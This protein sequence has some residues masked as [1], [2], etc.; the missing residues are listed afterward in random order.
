MYE[1]DTAPPKPLVV[2]ST[3]G[4]S[5]PGERWQLSPAALG[6]FLAALPAPMTL[7]NVELADGT[8]TTG[9]VANEPAGRDI[10]GAGG[11]RAH[12]S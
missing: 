10:T 2:R 3:N 12:R 11:W 9:F 7:G 1:L 6:T 8:W 4:T 5:L